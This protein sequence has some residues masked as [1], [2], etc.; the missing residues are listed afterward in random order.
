MLA[1]RRRDVV[2]LAARTRLACERAE[3]A[4]VRLERARARF[5]GNSVNLLLPFTAGMLGGA[6]ALYRKPPTE[7]GKP[8]G[9]RKEGIS[10][11]SL[12]ATGSALWS[13][14]AT[15]REALRAER[16]EP[17]PSPDGPPA[18]ESAMP[19]PGA[20]DDETG[21]ANGTVQPAPPPA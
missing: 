10:L 12:I 19:P 11:R 13:A 7:A 15:L 2:E 16:F 17:P 5:L 6:L 21:R 3:R 4:G 18:P 9:G 20:V 8:G 14:S 1:R